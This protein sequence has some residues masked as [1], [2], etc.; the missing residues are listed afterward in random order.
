M[1]IDLTPYVLSQFNVLVD[2]PQETLSE[3]RNQVLLEKFKLGWE[4]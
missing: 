2:I 4:I 3:I 1:P